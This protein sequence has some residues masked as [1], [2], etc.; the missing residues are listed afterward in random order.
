MMLTID[1]DG[2]PIPIIELV[3]FFA[4]YDLAIDP[5][6]AGQL[7]VKPG[8]DILQKH[9]APRCQLRKGRWSGQARYQK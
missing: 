1:L 7:T 4:R 3:R 2:C 5:K 6:G 9:P 8:K